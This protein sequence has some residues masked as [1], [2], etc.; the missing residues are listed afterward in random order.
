M[1]PPNTPNHISNVI[2][3]TL[4]SICETIGLERFD[5]LFGLKKSPAT[6]VRN[7][8]FFTVAGLSHAWRKLAYF[9]RTFVTCPSTLTI[10]KPAPTLSDDI[11][12]PD[13]LYTA[14]FS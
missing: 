12:M 1:S 7:R 9:T 10:Y 11:F 14:T 3:P 13:I 5:A 8:A 6:D 2:N 4:N